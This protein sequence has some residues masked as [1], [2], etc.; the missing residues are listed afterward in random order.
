MASE[1]QQPPS[2]V[3]ID[4]CPQCRSTNVVGFT[5]E[6]EGNIATQEIVCDDCDA[7]WNAMFHFQNHVIT[8]PG[9][10]ADASHD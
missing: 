3:G 8:F 1:K 2:T 6:V 9:D 10:T 5:P 7:E 4:V